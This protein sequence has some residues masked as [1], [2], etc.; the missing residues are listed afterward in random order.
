LIC[1]KIKPDK[2][3]DVNVSAILEPA[4]G[5]DQLGD[6]VFRVHERQT[7]S[8]H[9]VHGGTR[10]HRAAAGAVTAPAGSHPRPGAPG[11]PSHHPGDVGWG[12][13]L[14]ARL[15]HQA[16]RSSGRCRH[17][18]RYVC[19]LGNQNLENDSYPSFWAL[20]FLSLTSS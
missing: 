7:G 5:S 12:G 6:S 9:P 3:S 11:L 13:A 16:G 20:R 4:D 19:I 2:I 14:P 10:P 17:Q 15:G 1:V 18:K 8:E